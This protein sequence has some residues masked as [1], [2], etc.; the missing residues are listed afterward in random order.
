MIAESNKRQGLGNYKR[1][2]KFLV[3]NCNDAP[4]LTYKS[5]YI[6]NLDDMNEVDKRISA[7]IIL[8]KHS[9]KELHLH[10][11]KRFSEAIK[12]NNPTDQ[13]VWC[14][15]T[16]RLS[17]LVKVKCGKNKSKWISDTRGKYLYDNLIKKELE[18]IKSILKWYEGYLG[19]TLKKS[20]QLDLYNKQQKRIKEVCIGISNQRL[21]TAIKKEIADTVKLTDMFAEV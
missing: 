5:D 20:D 2:L 15:D 19:E 11:F 3:E 13:S 4:P 9:R 18:F 21:G 12:T 1:A 7:E 17:Y 6:K 14:S 16:T 10:L 8:S